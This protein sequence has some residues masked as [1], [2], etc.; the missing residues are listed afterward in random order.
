MR[1]VA[2]LDRGLH[3]RSIPLFGD[4][5]AERIA[6]LTEYANEELIGAGTVF[7]HAGVPVEMLRVV[8]E[9][10]VSS[11]LP[12]GKKFQMGPDSVIGVFEFFSGNSR[13]AFIAVTDVVALAIPT[14]AIR[15]IMD[16]HFDVVVHILRGLGRTLIRALAMA[17]TLSGSAAAPILEPHEHDLKEFGE[18]E[19]ILALRDTLAFKGASVDALAAVARGTRVVTYKKGDYLWGD[20]DSATWLGVIVH[21]VVECATSIR[22]E[23]FYFSE[24]G[25]SAVG[26]LD[27]LADDQR[28]YSALAM[29]DIVILVIQ[30]DDLFDTLE[31]HFEM[32]L[33]CLA[34]FSV[35]S[36]RIVDSLHGFGLPGTDGTSIPYGDVAA[37]SSLR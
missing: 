29:T 11:E 20:K 7:Q 14:T 28:W 3:L 5:P 22:P 19:R 2:P 27:T 31:D 15:D 36:T 24:K 21:G 18:V 33:A 37:P 6:M 17:P 4:L 34:A 13:A 25:P 26:F 8:V 32:T 16:E 1:F 12:D 30:K 35:F 10:D 23:R 9:G